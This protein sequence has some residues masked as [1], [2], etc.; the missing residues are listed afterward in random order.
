MRVDPEAKLGVRIDPREFLHC[1]FQGDGLPGVEHSEGVT[2][3]CR[4]RE[5]G[6]HDGRQT[7]D[8][9]VHGHRE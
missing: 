5:R 2:R 1:V 4:C 6:Y 8:F 3:K 7:H 9:Q